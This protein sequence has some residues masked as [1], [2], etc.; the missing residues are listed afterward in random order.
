[1]LTEYLAHIIQSPMNAHTLRKPLID[2][3]HNKNTLKHMN[4][5]KQNAY[6]IS[7]NLQ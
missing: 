1:M 3:L 7:D 5:H 2:V 4:K 6:R